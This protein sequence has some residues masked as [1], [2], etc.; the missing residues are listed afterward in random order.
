MV[1]PNDTCTTISVAQDVS[2]M[3]IIDLNCLKPDGTD[4]RANATM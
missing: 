2:T 1:V 3:G 4:L